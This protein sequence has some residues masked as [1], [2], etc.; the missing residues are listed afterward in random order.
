MEKQK[1]ISYMAYQASEVLGFM[2]F[3]AMLVAV[4]RLTHLQDQVQSVSS[5]AY[6]MTM[7][8]M[9]LIGFALYMGGATMRELVV[10]WAGIETWT[11]QAILMSMSS[12]IVQIG[13]ACVYIRAATTPRCKELGWIIV[14]AMA[15]MFSLASPL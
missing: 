15:L 14:L 12:R 6:D 9:F 8:R 4:W 2:S 1:L 11:E 10:L 13:G 5:V 3:I 7:R